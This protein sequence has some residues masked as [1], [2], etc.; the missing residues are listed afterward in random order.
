MTTRR[1]RVPSEAASG[2]EITAPAIVRTD[3]VRDRMLT[4]AAGAPKGWRR[5]SSLE[6]AYER[7]QLGG[8]SPL[9]DADK[10]L[11]AGEA[12]ARLYARSRASGRDSTD[13]DRIGGGH[14]DTF[15]E[16]QAR[17]LHTL[18]EIERRMNARDRM[19][20]RMVCGESHFPSEAVRIACNDY[21]H[22]V[23]SRFR[24]ALDSLIEAM[25]S[26]RESRKGQARAKSRVS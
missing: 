20:V 23:A 1:R 17:A 15:S 11:A 25:D 21:R 5:V 9:Y 22:M 12:F 4:A 2:D 7:G 16:A 8:G 3:H 14:G 19:I 13:L 24:E 26:L 10:R 18:G 6:A